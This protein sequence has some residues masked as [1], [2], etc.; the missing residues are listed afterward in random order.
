MGENTRKT[1]S[2]FEVDEEHAREKAVNAAQAHELRLPLCRSSNVG[3][4]SY[5]DLPAHAEF[6]YV[7][8]ATSPRR[9]A[10]GSCA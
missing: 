1:C 3:L 6:G 7:Q 4:K 9:A 5:R 8:T 2:S 10:R